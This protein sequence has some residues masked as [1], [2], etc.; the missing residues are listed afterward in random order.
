[1]S[2]N[3]RVLKDDLD[4]SSERLSIHEV[5]YEKKDEEEVPTFYTQNAVAPKG[6]NLEELRADVSQYIEALDK[7]VLSKSSIDGPS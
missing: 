6:E 7:P 4:R 5:Y 2:W 3:Y 1:M